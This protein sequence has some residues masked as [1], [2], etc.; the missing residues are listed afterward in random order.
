MNDYETRIAIDWAKGKI[1]DHLINGLTYSA[2]QLEELVRC[3]KLCITADKVID[4]MTD[5]LSKEVE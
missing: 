2:S 4:E 1:K 3:A 5:K